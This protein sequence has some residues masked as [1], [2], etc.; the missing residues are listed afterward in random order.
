MRKNLLISFVAHILV[1]ALMLVDI[2]L[3]TQKQDKAPP[4]VLMVDLTKVQIA[5]K[6]NLPQKINKAVTQNKLT[7]S[8]PLEN[9]KTPKKT[10]VKQTNK[11]ALKTQEKAISKNAASIKSSEK[12]KEIKPKEKVTNQPMNQKQS[13]DFKSLL[14]SVE[15]VRQAP[16]PTQ[17]KENTSA[18]TNGEEVNLAQILTI[19]ERDLIAYKLKECWNVDAGIEGIEDIIID[20]QAFI[21]KDGHVREVKIK[22]NLTSQAM[23]AVAESARRAILICDNKGNDSPFKILAEKYA[24]HYNQWKELELRF[25][26]LEGSIF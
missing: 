21:N 7:P 10:P 12:K 3:F 18:I 9:K 13:Y 1:I 6:T 24:N 17:Q 26:P 11:T 22:N 25:N 4:A 16:A 23:K 20:I 8:K 15:K 5:E 14:A 19:S 2:N